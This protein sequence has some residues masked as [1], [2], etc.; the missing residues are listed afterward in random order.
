MAF[1]TA[2]Q[3]KFGRRDGFAMISV[4]MLIALLGVTVVPMMDMIKRSKENQIK[5][6]VIA[7]LVQEARENLEVA[8][9]LVKA[10]EGVPNGYAT[11]PSPQVENIAK[12][13]SNRIAAIDPD[14][15]GVEG[16]TNTSTVFN[17]LATK[18]N[19]RLVAS[20]V[21]D[22]STDPRFLRYTIVSC[23]SAETGEIGIYAAELAAL[24]GA[25][26]TLSFGQF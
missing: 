25:F 24:E 8:V 20:F 26:Y 23:A 17:T 16:L 1:I 3:Q 14:L 5:Q 13:C 9:Y 10:A 15:L 19:N 7:H 4:L 18:A 2:V 11:T 6:R 22:R 12:S 21:V